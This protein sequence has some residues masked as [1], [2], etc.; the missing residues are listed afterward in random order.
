[1]ADKTIICK[2]CGKE[3]VFTEGEQEFYKEKGFENDP[4]RCPECRKKRK[5]EKN[6]MRR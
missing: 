1:M 2:D 3:F 4:V 6:R 5:A